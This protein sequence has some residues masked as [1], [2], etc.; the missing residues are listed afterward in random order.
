MKRI[1]IEDNKPVT[2]SGLSQADTFGKNINIVYGYVTNIYIKLA[3]VSVK[4]DNGI[5]IKYVSVPSRE[6]ESGDGAGKTDMPPVGS[7]V[8]V[9]FPYGQQNISGVRVQDS[10]IDIKKDTD[11]LVTGEENKITH[12][13]KGGIQTVYDRSTGN[14]IIT[15]KDNSS[16]SI[17]INKKNSIISV[18]DWNSNKFVMNSDGI[19]ITDKNNNTIAMASGKVTIN[20]HL[21][22]TS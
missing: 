9:F 21:E 17:T 14:Y 15:D 5:T 12:L 16:F 11:R 3:A 7:R 4:L 8:S 20:S 10:P 18:T 6:W 19:N 13:L 2:Q 1:I 22:V